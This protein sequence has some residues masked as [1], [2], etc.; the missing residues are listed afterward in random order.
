[1]NINSVV[2]LLGK[3]L[4]NNQLTLEGR[5]R[6]E[7]LARSSP[8]LDVKTTLIVVCGGVTDNQNVSEAR[9]MMDYLSQL[10]PADVLGG[11]QIV[12][13]NESQNT[14]ENLSNAAM[15]LIQCPGYQI[16]RCLN[17][18]LLSNDYHLKRIVEIEQLMPEQ[19]LISK[20][21]ERCRQ[22]GLEVSVGSQLEHHHAVPYPHKGTRAEAFLYC[23]ELTTY[24]V[25]LEGVKA[26]VFAR[27][28]S[29]V[30]RA[31]Y[32]IAQRAI[33]RLQA[34]PLNQQEHAL[35]LEIKSLVEATAENSAYSHCVDA[36]QRL[37]KA[38]TQLNRWLDPET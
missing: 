18:T 4:V 12:L 33:E 14:I 25:Y 9:A 37:D 11:Y 24:R 22:V 32:Q 34:L 5:S 15:K 21:V 26:R 10:L 3:R 13:E 38:L 6:V 36:L 20:M 16:G 27:P 31:P 7:H 17:I 2:L 30:R 28:L 1:M 23:D 29:G 35:V 19:G 8:L